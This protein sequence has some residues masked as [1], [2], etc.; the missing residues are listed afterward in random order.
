MDT[1][2]AL[3]DKDEFNETIKHLERIKKEGMTFVEEYVQHITGNKKMDPREFQRRYTYSPL[4]YFHK[5]LG[6]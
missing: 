6:I 3:I 4:K 2:D 1:K 5:E